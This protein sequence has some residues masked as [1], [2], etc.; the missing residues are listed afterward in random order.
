MARRADLASAVCVARA[1]VKWKAPTRVVLVAAKNASK[2]E[3][4]TLI[5]AIWPSTLITENTDEKYQHI[6]K[7]APF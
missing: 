7:M 5:F 2:I 1:G 6:C 3:V 4:T